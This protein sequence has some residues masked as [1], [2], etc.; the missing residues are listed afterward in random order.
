[1]H[2]TC[3]IVL[4]F[5]HDLSD[6]MFYF[7]FSVQLIFDTPCLYHRQAMALRR[8]AAGV[9]EVSD[10]LECLALEDYEPESPYMSEVS[11]WS[12]LKFR[13]QLLTIKFSYRTLKTKHCGN[14]QVSNKFGRFSF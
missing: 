2:C 9:D 14:N 1:M 13:L 10:R 3:A 4:L 5:C 8:N 11:F 12:F 6:F 7:N